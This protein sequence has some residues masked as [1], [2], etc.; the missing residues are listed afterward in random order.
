[1]SRLFFALDISTT[2]KN[3]IDEYR[4]RCIF[5]DFK[6][7]SK[8]NLHITLCF[9][10]AVSTLQQQVLITKAN[11]LA[12]TLYPIAPHQLLLNKLSLFKKP[13]IIYLTSNHTPKWLLTL[14]SELSSCAKDLTLFQENRP[15]LAHISIYR[16]ASFL[17]KV[18]PSPQLNIT[19]ES[20][21]LYQ[22]TSTDNGVAYQKI[23][24]WVLL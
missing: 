1:M 6:P 5:T 2:D 12:K 10:G 22:S 3:L 19:I 20:F 16:K 17:P 23:K 14:A 24:T 21:S 9:L 11:V 15:Y 7:V 13:K 8:N 18:N 4:E